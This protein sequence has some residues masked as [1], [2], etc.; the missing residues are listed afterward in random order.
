MANFYVHAGNWLTNVNSLR[1]TFTVTE[2]SNRIID[3]IK[4][5][6]PIEVDAD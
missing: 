5:V 3:D 1:H 2:L 4:Q 6:D